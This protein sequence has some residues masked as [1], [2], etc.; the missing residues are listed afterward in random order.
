MEA[1]LQQ[2]GAGNAPLAPVPRTA[3]LTSALHE[4]RPETPLQ[5]TPLAA[6]NMITLAKAEATAERNGIDKTV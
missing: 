4:R 2:V 6:P 1:V 3:T 5:H